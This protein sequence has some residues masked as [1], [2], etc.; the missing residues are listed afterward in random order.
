MGNSYGPTARYMRTIGLLREKA[1]PPTKRQKKMFGSR[2]TDQDILTGQLR[3][4]KHAIEALEN[5]RDILELADSPWVLVKAEAAIA[6]A[7]KAKDRLQLRC[8]MA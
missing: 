6:A 3:A 1:R 5:A 4:M 2:V 7:H 8:P